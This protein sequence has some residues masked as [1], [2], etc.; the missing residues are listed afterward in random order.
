MFQQIWVLELITDKALEWYPV[1]ESMQ[2][3]LREVVIVEWIPVI[4]FGAVAVWFGYSA[5]NNAEGDM[6]LDDDEVEKTAQ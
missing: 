2:G 3:P 6:P 4:L 5:L 1:T